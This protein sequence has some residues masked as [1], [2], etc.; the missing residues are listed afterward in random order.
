MGDPYSSA[1]SGFVGLIKFAGLYGILAWFVCG[2]FC[3]HVASEKSRC[4]I[5]WFLWGIGFGPMAL[6]AVVGLPDK[7]PLKEAEAPPLRVRGEHTL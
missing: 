2:A 1:A 7:T 5:C 4:A 3:S 6:L